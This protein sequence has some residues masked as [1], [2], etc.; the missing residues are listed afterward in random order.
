MQVSKD[1]AYYYDGQSMGMR[2][3]GQKSIEQ[4]RKKVAILQLQESYPER[5]MY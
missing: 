2:S 4:Q 1:C 5:I 3:G